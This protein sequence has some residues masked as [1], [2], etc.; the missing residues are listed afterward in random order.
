MGD[1]GTKDPITSADKLQ[2]SEDGERRGGT[3]WLRE[4]PTLHG[5]GS[6]GRNRKDAYGWSAEFEHCIS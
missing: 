1:P 2:G 6:W 3:P 4:V 5:V